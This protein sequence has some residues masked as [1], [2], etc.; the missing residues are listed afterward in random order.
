MSDEEINNRKGKQIK[1]K[2]GA[3]RDFLLVGIGAS[4]GGIKALKEFFAAMPADSGMAFVV[5]LHL[6]QTHKSN[7]AEILQRETEM[8]VEQVTETVKVEPNKVYVIPPAKHLELTDGIIKLKEPERVKGVRV[9]IDRFFRSLADAYGTKAVCIILSGTGSDG[10]NGMKHVKGKD[11][12]AIVQDPRDAEYDGM[13]RSAIET[14]IAD[15]VLPIAEMPEKLLFVRDTTEKFRLTD[16]KDGEVAKEIKNIEL[17]RDVLTL[18][19]VRTGHDFSNYKRPT[20]VRRAARHLQI[21]ETDDLEVYLKILRERPDEVLSLLKNLLINVT[22]FFRDKDA[23][24][25]LEKTVIPALFEGK[26]SEN[27][28]RVWVAGCATGEEAYSMA[29][30]LQEYAANLPDPPKIQVFASDV[31][32][33]AIAGAREGRF[34]EA[35]VSDV[36]PERLRQFFVKEED[37]G[38]WIR[39]AIREMVLFAPHN[40]LRD[41]PFSRLDLISCRNVLIYLNRETQEKVLRVF[42]FALREGGFLFLGSSESAE[43]TANIFSAIDKKHRIYQCRPSSA[44][45]NAPP[46][47]PLTGAWSPKISDY[48][49]RTRGFL[50]SFGELHHRLIEQY[51]PPSVLVNEE[52]DIL[53]SSENV[54]RFLRFAGG[55][56][57]ANLLKVVH[58]DLLSDVRAALF[59]ARKEN[60]TV[61]AKSI[62]VKFDAEEKFVNLT[63]RPVGTPEAAALVIFEEIGDAP[64]GEE[65]V[66]AIVAG[67]KAMESVVRRME[68]ELRNTKDQLRNTIEQYETS[69]E[70]QKAANEELQAINEELRSASEEL[71]T[72]KEELQ[73]VN[74]ELTTVNHELKDK[75][76]EVTRTHSD[77]QYLMQSTDIATIFLDRELKIKRYTP[78]ATEI[79]NLIPADV[80]RP[81]AHITHRLEP[82]NFAADAAVSLRNLKTFEREVRSSDD[83]FFIA[84]ISP[85]RTLDDRIDG[86][87]ISFIDVTERDKA[88]QLVREERA[89]AEAIVETVREPLVILAAGLRVVSA[90]RSFYEVFKVTPEETEGKFI[91]DLGN[92]QWDIPALREL[93]EDI[94]PRHSQFQ[95]FEVEH[96][97][98][99]IG[100]RTMLLNAREIYLQS[101]NKRLIL[102]AIE[103]VTKQRQAEE[104]ARANEQRLRRMV[105]VPRVGVLTFDHAGAMLHANDAFLEMVGYDRT[106]FAAKELTWRDFTPPEYTEASEEMLKLIRE[107]GRGE[108][109]EKEYFRKDGSR[110]WLMFVA[111][112]L[113]DGTLVEYALDISERK[114]TEEALRESEERLAADLAGMRRLYELHAK[115]ASETDLRAALEEILA[116]ACEFT[117]TER[118]CVQL[119]SDD[120]ERLEMFAWRGYADDSLFISHFRHEG[121]RAACDMARQHGK[122]LI[123]EDVENFPPL[124]GTRDLEVALAENIR[125][126][127]ST[128][129]K[130][131][132]AEMVGV[133]SNQFSQPHRLTADELRLIDLLAWTAAN[134]VERHRADETRREKETLQ[135][136]IGAQEDERR[137]I[138]QDIHDHLGQQLTALRLKLEIIKQNGGELDEKLLA[139][140]D[141]T[142]TIAQKIDADIDF[143]AWEMRPSALDDLGLS[144]ALERY[145]REWSRQFSVPVDFRADKFGA[146]RIAP[147]AE[148]NL[149]RI[150]QEI[151]NNI[152]KHARANQI[153]VSLEHRD[154]FA[155]LIIEDNGIGFDAK[156]KNR[157]G[158]GLSGMQERA[159]LI[160]GTLKIE[161]A[162]GEGT[163]I[164]V[165]VPLEKGEK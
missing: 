114:R 138:A 34:T 107:T 42:H 44:A 78:R 86:V 62:R 132:Q 65:S 137:R 11:G 129:M 126:T 30:L 47:M 163:T 76:D 10:T 71:E 49:P 108:P 74:E 60:K 97:F 39:K 1:E 3:K 54:W 134:F 21:H 89:Y 152:I 84:R 139:Q 35:I 111:A 69:N 73:S 32:D 101:K 87:V 122:R 56:P 14:R 125:A 4:A 92:Q 6:S 105:N 57:T 142:Q 12:F 59:T 5:I 85:Y 154:R 91:Y 82:D 133:L 7:L 165:R 145:V 41:P 70:E 124:A 23:F 64:Q 27:Q 51:A 75:V 16:G 109:Y 29:I 80:G 104:A 63:V 33:D 26:T 140:I 121:S 102:L 95:D 79:F 88:E 45:W 153:D 43:S 37:D 110:I 106:E 160:G 2:A 99:T 96:D 72:S 15:V 131:M 130:T 20:L 113:G 149:Y 100:R 66:Q 61:E 28:V 8:A 143:L 36:S 24:D 77:L 52:G 135:K 22:N 38:Y 9:P 141:E 146:Y 17:L 25:A 13:P 115:L 83:R 40:I 127:Q 98:E 67:D 151:L 48:P 128:P 103:D 123:I 53:H 93:L 50:Q 164:F 150:A 55:D 112:D 46:G 58:P 118:G 116:T 161:T 119:V 157:Q 158:M 31:D 162:P 19:K 156:E 81:L 117:G 136:I 120:G 90:N 155:V 144:A 94:L 68:D 18:L 148:T 147:E 159:E